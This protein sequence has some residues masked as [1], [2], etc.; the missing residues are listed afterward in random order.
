MDKAVKAIARK[1]GEVEA[2]PLQKL[3]QVIKI[4]S[5]EQAHSFCDKALEIDGQGGMMTNDGSRRRSVGGIFFHLVRG[6]GN[7]E[8][9]KLWKPRQK[10]RTPKTD[11]PHV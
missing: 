9:K 3:E 11:K 7:E 5:V 6:S 2:E 4:I 10:Q 8:I 1:L